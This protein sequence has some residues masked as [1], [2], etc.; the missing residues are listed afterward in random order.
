MQISRLVTAVSSGA[1]TDCVFPTGGVAT[2]L[3][4]APIIQT[5]PIARSSVVR[6]INSFVLKD[7]PPTDR[8]VSNGQS[9][10]TEYVTA[11]IQPMRKSNAVSFFSISF[12]L[13]VVICYVITIEKK[14]NSRKTVANTKSF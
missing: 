7:R 9:C 3:P 5:R 1:T 11:P 10:A 13:V 2:V 14:N 4:I 12:S 6:T 8:N